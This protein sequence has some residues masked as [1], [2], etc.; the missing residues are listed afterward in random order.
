MQDAK[1]A[2]NYVNHLNT[3]FHGSKKHINTKEKARCMWDKKWVK[4]LKK[5]WV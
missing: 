4:G 1:T 2:L 3:C 5:D